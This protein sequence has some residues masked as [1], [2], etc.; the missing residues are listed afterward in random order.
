MDMAR[1]V[2]RH[3]SPL[4]LVLY[5]RDTCPYCVRVARVIEQLG[6]AVPTRDTQRDPGALEELVR[7][8]GFRQVPMLL[9]NG[10]A[11]YESSDIIDYLRNEVRVA[12]GA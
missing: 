8:G 1:L 10:A 6:I 3:G 5:K 2:D 9:I 7:L 4:D 12:E 11:L